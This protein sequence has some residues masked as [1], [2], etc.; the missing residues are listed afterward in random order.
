M[1]F[2]VAKSAGLSAPVTEE[3]CTLSSGHVT[4]CLKIQLKGAPADHAVGPFCPRTITDPASGTV[5]VK[6]TIENSSGEHRSGVRCA[7][8]A[9]E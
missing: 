8:A 9:Q 4:T 3:D 5:R 7:L 1:K 6:F 2:F